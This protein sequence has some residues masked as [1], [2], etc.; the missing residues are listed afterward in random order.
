MEKL[1]ESLVKGV[2]N[3]DTVILSGKM[4]KNSDEAPEEKTLYLS[5]ISAPKCGSSNN[6]DEDPFGWDS[7]DFLRQHVLGKVIKYTIDYKNNDRQFGQ[8]YLDSKNINLDIVKN[9]FAKV[10]FA[11]KKENTFPN[12]N[13]LSSRRKRT[14]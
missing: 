7:R 6:L 8:I 11:A 1:Q 5:L 9:G 12:F 13:Q 14:N 3:G 4:K 2:P 10:N